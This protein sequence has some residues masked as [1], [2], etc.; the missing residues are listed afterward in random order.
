MRE[1][2]MLPVPG[3]RF[4]DARLRALIRR[5][6]LGLVPDPAFDRI[7]ALVARLLDMPVVLVSRPPPRADGAPGHTYY[8][9]EVQPAHR[10]AGLFESAIPGNGPYI[11]RDALVDARTAAHPLVA[12]EFGLRFYAAVPL[13]SATRL[14]PGFLCCIDF[15]ARNFDTAAIDI[16]RGFAEI[17]MDQIELQQA[18]HGG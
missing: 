5:G 17:V 13:Q 7:T 4:D 15:Q 10:V 2:T 1:A 6:T 11:V 9:L 18:A 14:H 8:G 16:L 12:G 3:S